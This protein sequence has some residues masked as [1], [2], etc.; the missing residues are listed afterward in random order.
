[1]SHCLQQ[2][3]IRYWLDNPITTITGALKS[4][5]LFWAPIHQFAVTQPNSLVPD[6]ARIPVH[7]DFLDIFLATLHQMTNTK[8]KLLQARL[9]LDPIK[10][11]D[12]VGATVLVIPFLPEVIYLLNFTVIHFLPILLLYGIVCKLKNKRTILWPNGLG[13]LLIIYCYL[14]A[15][16][17]LIEYG[18]NM[19]FRMEVEPIIWTITAITVQMVW[20]H[21][22]KII[23][24]RN[25]VLSQKR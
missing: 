2:A 23:R 3:Y 16:S 8:Y 17:S 25:G 13:F 9:S 12:W 10:E 5:Q 11:E 19:R 20:Q 14:A 4:Y 7:A 24:N 6:I 21:G 1:M 22:M 18:E 15:L